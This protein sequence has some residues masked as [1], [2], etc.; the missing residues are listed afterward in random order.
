MTTSKKKS[1]KRQKHSQVKPLNPGL[2]LSV[3]L[4]LSGLVPTGTPMQ[5]GCR[6]MA[7]CV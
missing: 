3:F 7:L 6:S 2:F 1:F 4:L 5:P